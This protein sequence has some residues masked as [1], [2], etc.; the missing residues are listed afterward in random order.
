[1]KKAI[2]SALFILTLAWLPS[3]CVMMPEVIEEMQLD[4]C[5]TPTNLSLTEAGESVTFSWTTSK[6]STSYTIEIYSDPENPDESTKYTKEGITAE[7]IPYTFPGLEKDLTLY[8]RIKGV[9][10][11][12]GDSRWAT[13]RSFETYAP[14]PS[15]ENLAVE[16][17]TSSSIEVS[18][19][20]AEDKDVS[21]IRYALASDPDYKS[22]YEVKELSET[23]IEAGAVTVSGLESAEKYIFTV[24]FGNTPRGSV[25]AYT[26]PDVDETTTAHDSEDLVQFLNDGAAEIYLAYSETPYD[27]GF[28]IEEGETVLLSLEELDHSVA[29]Y[30]LEKDGEPGV[31][32]VVYGNLQIVD[33]AEG[34]PEATEGISVILENIAF[35]GKDYTTAHVISVGKSLNTPLNTIS[36]RNCTLTRFKRG[37]FA[38]NNDVTVPSIGSLLFD[39]IVVSD[40]DGSGAE[41]I[42]VR[43][44]TSIGTISITNSTLTDGCREMLRVDDS[45]GS[46]LSKLIVRN[47]TFNNLC[48]QSGGGLFYSCP[49]PTTF[50]FVGNIFLNMNAAKYTSTSVWGREGHTPVPTEISSNFFYNVGGNFFEPAPE[51]ATEK[52]FTQDLAISN[53]GAVLKEDPC[54]ESVT[55]NFHIM[56]QTVFAASA[57][58]PR[59]LVEGYVEP[60]EPL[61]LTPVTPPYSWDFTDAESF[62]NSADK[63]MVRGNIR[64]YISSNPVEFDTENGRLYFTAAGEM[65]AT[66]PMDCAIGFQV[67]KPGSLVV[68]ASPY[69]GYQEAHITVSVDGEHVGA[70]PV[71]AEDYQIS[72]ASVVEEGKVS[73]VYLY[74]CDP[75]YLT[76]LEYSDYIGG[77]DTKLATPENISISAASATVESS[78]PVTVS[79]DAVANAGSYDIMYGEEVF[80]NTS[81]PGYSIVPSQMAASYAPGPYEFT[82]VARPRDDDGIREA[83]DPSVPFTFDLLEVLKPVSVAGTTV[84]GSSDFEWMNNLIGSNGSNIE[85]EWTYYVHNNLMYYNNDKIRF[86]SS[87]GR[88]YWQFPGS[89]NNPPTRRYLSFIAGGPGKLTVIM[90]NAS[91]P[92]PTEPRY[93]QLMTGNAAPDGVV[94]DLQFE[95]TSNSEDLAAEWVLNDLTA[96][97]YITIFANQGIRV[98]SITW[99]PGMHAAAGQLE[100]PKVTIDQPAVL[101]GTESVTASW[102]A[103]SGAT[104]YDV[105]V[106]GGSPVNV[107]ATTYTVQLSGLSLG[108]HTVSVVAK[109]AGSTDSYA[110]SATFDIVAEG[111]LVPVSSTAPTTWGAEDFATLMAQYGSGVNITE[112]FVYNNLKFLMGGGKGKFGE[113]KN[114]SGVSQARY[115]FGGSGST[116]KNCLQFIVPGPGTLA[117]EYESS[118]S[119]VR[120]LAISVDDAEQTVAAPVDPVIETATLSNA[121]SGSVISIYSKNKGIN[122]FSVTW[123][124]AQ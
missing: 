101:E 2:L 52:A 36:F 73:T 99:E 5:L 26:L 38:M 103:V 105:T 50:E 83:S 55:G 10:D 89:S 35:D 61:D 53:G 40:T 16:E 20:A 114:A 15:V 104:S 92:D 80:A 63:N 51:S 108:Q 3:G 34:T 109:A 102:Q 116:S 123:T 120:E 6:G 18:W 47:N 121:S 39:D 119:E 95:A 91:A 66:E 96:G 9:S 75:F 30:G 58:D 115:Q 42:G 112:D 85:T 67:D 72:L 110:G 81:E 62:Y 21:A 17:R 117:V 76:G 60:V 48:T 113:N 24:H 33:A 37:L 7:N 1:M 70:V 45:D 49:D 14:R 54:A 43:K 59:W 41:M 12:I 57:G 25:S 82:V 31:F 69:P 22:N 56:D 77:G 106:D 23:E 124:P 87:D 111:G 94:N 107:T 100:T 74:G 32:P 19:S 86:N 84:W 71:D 98:Y 122:I 46:S 28:A 93:L 97:D 8:A 11:V 68:S 27:L 44:P 64:F 4:R 118:G 78:D 65:G 88:Y 13:F 29:I 90:Q 79:W